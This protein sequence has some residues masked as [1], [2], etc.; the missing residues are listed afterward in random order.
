MLKGTLNAEQ[1]TTRCQ[2]AEAL[3]EKIKLYE[4]EFR[5]G[6]DDLKQAAEKANQV[7]AAALLKELTGSGVGI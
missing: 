4:Q 7:A 5:L 2:D 6:L 1:M 3:L